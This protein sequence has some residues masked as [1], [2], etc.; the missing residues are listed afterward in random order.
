M[1][2]DPYPPYDPRLAAG[3]DARPEVEVAGPKEKGCVV[4]LEH[5]LGVV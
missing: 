4:G 3:A 2:L 1:R 5:E